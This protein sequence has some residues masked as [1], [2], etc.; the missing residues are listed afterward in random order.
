M[1]ATAKIKTASAL[2]P[3]ELR[4]LTKRVLSDYLGAKSAAKLAK[5]VPREALEDVLRTLRASK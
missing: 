5:S 3:A 4:Q 2:T 1:S